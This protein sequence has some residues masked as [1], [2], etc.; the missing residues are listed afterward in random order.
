MGLQFDVDLI[1]YV[2]LPIMFITLLLKLVFC[3]CKINSIFQL[4]NY[5]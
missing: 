4:K 2:T 1:V 5:M 3:K